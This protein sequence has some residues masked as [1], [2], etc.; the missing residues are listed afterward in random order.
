MLEFIDYY[1]ICLWNTYGVFHLIIVFDT[2]LI[3]S[4]NQDEVGPSHKSDDEDENDQAKTK[5]SFTVMMSSSSGASRKPS[6]VADSDVADQ[7][8]D[9]LRVL[10]VDDD[11]VCLTILGTMLTNCKYQVTKCNR[12]EVA[13]SLL[14]ENKNGYDVVISDVHMP[15]MDGFKLLVHIGL[16][17]DLPVITD[18]IK[19]VVM[20]GVTHGACDYLI[21]PVRIE[22]LRNIW[23]H[24]IRK[25]KHEWKD[26][27]QKSHEQDPESSSANEG[28]NG[29]ITK[30]RKEDE[31]ETYERDDSS[32]LKKPRVAWNRD[33]HEQFVAAVCH[34]GYENA[35][36]K[37]ILEVMNVPG[38]TRENVASHLQKYRNYLRSLSGSQQSGG[39]NT[40]FMDKP[41]VGYGST[42][43][44]SP[45]S[46]PLANQRNIFSF[47][48]PKMRNGPT[49]NWQGQNGNI[50]KQTNFLLEIIG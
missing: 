15:D 1:E 25:K 24:V 46:M 34:L 44:Y 28:Q 29:K 48:N 23:Q 14:R 22:A 18:D 31:E 40:S 43:S 6:G 11:S 4:N 16:E 20:K 38:L 13:L 50:S 36:P 17:M 47:E 3:P 35:V 8:P 9:G 27:E 21:K 10:A 32:S 26:I 37:K 19:S 7:F 41:N 39:I 12:A 30:K 45:V 33:L 49:Q 5:N 2:T 42:N